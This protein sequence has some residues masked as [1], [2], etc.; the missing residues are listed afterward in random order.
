MMFG[1]KW[2]SMMSTWSQS[3]PCSILA[4]HSL[5]RV[6]KSALRIEGAI[7]AGGD[8][9]GG[10]SGYVGGVIELEVVGFNGIVYIKSICTNGRRQRQRKKI[11][12]SGELWSG[13]K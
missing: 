13:I 4:E 2:P 11:K 5:P 3:A 10:E 1:T 12:K 9:V 8:M 7:I 6:A